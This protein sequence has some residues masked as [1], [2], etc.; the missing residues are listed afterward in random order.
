[1]AKWRF[2]E[3]AQPA[4]RAPAK[5]LSTVQSAGPQPASYFEKKSDLLYDLRRSLMWISEY[6]IVL[7]G[8]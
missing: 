3:F 8:V 5:G 2:T 6:I 4:A 1:M 7:S